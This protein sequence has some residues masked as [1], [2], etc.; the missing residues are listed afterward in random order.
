[1]NVIDNAALKQNIT[2][3]A[4]AILAAGLSLEDHLPGIVD[5]AV[6][7]ELAKLDAAIHGLLLPVLAAFA[8]L[9]KNFTRALIESAAWRDIFQR[10]NLSPPETPK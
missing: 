10:F 9:N 4:A 6:D 7:A 8:D 3:G 2:D 5:A 1:M